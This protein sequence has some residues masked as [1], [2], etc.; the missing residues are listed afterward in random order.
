M[1][2]L[3]FIVFAL[4]FE[5]LKNWNTRVTKRKKVREA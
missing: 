1:I 2:D 4:L 5:E 3:S